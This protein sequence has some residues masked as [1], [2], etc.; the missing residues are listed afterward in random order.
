MVKSYGDFLGGQNNNN[1][2]FK[3]K[4]NDNEKKEDTSYLDL[5]EANPSC[6][7]VDSTET[8]LK[9][10]SLVVIGLLYFASVLY[11]TY[12]LVLSIGIAGIVSISFVMAFH[13]KFFSFRHLFGFRSFEPLG[14]FVFWRVEKELDE[15]NLGTKDYK[16]V[17]FCTNRKDLSTTGVRIFKILVLPENVRE[18]LNRVYIGLHEL[19]V[20]FTYQILHRPLQTS[21]NRDG[22]ESSTFETIIYFSTFYNVKGRLTKSK[23]EEM[24]EGLRENAV[25]LESAFASNF[26][27]FKVV[28]LSGKE[29]EKAYRI[30]VLK[31][32]VE[33]EE[34]TDEISCETVKPKTVPTILR[35]SYVLAIVICLDRLLLIF[36]LP[37]M[38]QFLGTFAILTAILVI[39]WRELFFFAIK[40]KLFESEEIEVIDPFS[41]VKFF[42]VSKAPETIFYRVE[43][44]LIGGIKI[45]NMYFAYPPPYCSASKFYEALIYKKMPFSAT[46]QLTPLNFHQ[47]DKEGFDSLKEV[48]QQ[49]LLTRTNT[50]LDGKKWLTSRSGVWSTVITYSTSAF[51]KAPE[52]DYDVVKEIEQKLINRNLTLLTSFKQDFN[53]YG[54]KQLRKNELESGLLFETF[55]NKFF[56]RNGSHLSYLLFQ[57]KTLLMVTEISNQF[58][59]GLETRLAAEF[60]TP[61]HLTNFITVGN[62]INTEFLEHEV[63]M[64]FTLEQL[65]NLMVLNGT[66]SSR[67][68]LCQKIVEELVKAGYPSIVF[69]F[70]GN[71]SKLMRV[72][73]GTIHEDKF[74]YLKAGKTFLI[75]P[76]FSEIPYD[77]DNIGYLDYMFDAF[78]LCFK[79]DERTVEAFKNSIATNSDIEVSTL[80][81]DLDTKN[82]WEKSPTTDA[83]QSFFSEFTEN[84]VSSM[85]RQQQ[86]KQDVIPSYEMLTHDKTVIIDFSGTEN[87]D[88]KC[89]FSFVVLSKFIH[90]LRTEKAFYPKFLIVP[91][92]D[93]VFDGFFIDKKVNYGVIDK[94]LELFVK[95]G[96]GTI[97]SAS[98]ARHLHSNAF[99]YFQNLVVFKATDKRD[100]ATLKSLMN[101]ESLHGIGHYSRSRNEGYQLRY[102]ESM[103]KDEAVVKRED[104][105]QPFPVEFDLKELREIKPL[106]WEEI[107]S[108]QG[109]QGYDM[110]SAERLIIQR[111][112]KTLFQK[113]FGDYSVLIEGVI[114]FLNNLKKLDQ[115]GNLYEQK[116]KKELTQFLHPYIL[117][118][119]KDKKRE[120]EIKNK[121]FEI[122]VKHRYLIESHPKRAS[123]SESLQTSFAVGPHY[124]EAL[125]DYYEAQRKAV[126]SYEPLDVES[127]IFNVSNTSDISDNVSQVE[128]IDPKK[129]KNAFAEHFAPILHYEHFKMHQ[130]IKNKEFKKSLR[131]G[132]SLLR[133]FLQAS[134]NSYYG[135]DG[136]EAIA[137]VTN[138]IGSISKVEGFPFSESELTDFLTTCENASFEEESVEKRSKEN[139]E[140]YSKIFDRFKQYVEKDAEEV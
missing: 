40:S 116:I 140:I 97:C 118:V 8:V 43:G 4:A 134:C 93:L 98:Q 135:I 10:T 132:K 130:S 56:R 78:A 70:T 42:K 110:E 84:D 109:K 126:V 41:D 103:K 122:L 81:L 49:K 30:S 112:E 90:Y 95:K 104:I 68:A 62:T 80:T 18:N 29:L 111:A 64:G 133:K 136:E 123:G 102:I 74:L 105:Y 124:T 57:G 131:M 114:G 69:D 19:K 46:I 59:K 113:D 128:K 38:L 77:T 55:K 25:S 53:T 1:N 89:W 127:D 34:D 73:E 92:V 22:S 108:Y 67:E 48:E 71:W 117:K 2:K 125:E 91:H 5:W 31:Q 72:F 32:D 16:K 7:D 61:L 35:A 121:T 85:Q 26:H 39:W 66:N 107:V 51:S 50:V 24:F 86:R 75:N 139:F 3:P 21:V 106:S 79:K 82:Q 101:L 20:A 100:S 58:K 14:D 47:F 11:A 44:K 65:R 52:L 17:L 137:N 76:L 87:Y 88:K 27:H 23:L 83:I 138:F 120:K 60:N 6:K 115:I 36:N 15:L 28:E 96:F 45:N 9:A 13:K 94:F 119:T 54:L 12:N 99:N 129:L 33:I 63:P 37:I